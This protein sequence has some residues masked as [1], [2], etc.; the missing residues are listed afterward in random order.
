M[1]WGSRWIKDGTREWDFNFGGREELLRGRDLAWHGFSLY[2][3]RDGVDDLIPWLDAIH[4][5]IW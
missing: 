4:L 3:Y 2:N 1:D 5:S